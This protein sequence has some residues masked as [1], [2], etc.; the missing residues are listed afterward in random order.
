VRCGNPTHVTW[1]KAPKNI[2]GA[3]EALKKVGYSRLLAD[4]DVDANWM[5]LGDIALLRPLRGTLEELL[6]VRQGGTV[7]PY[8]AAFWKRRAAEGNANNAAHV[9]N[10]IQAIVIKGKP[11]PVDETLVNNDVYELVTLYV[12]GR[13]GADAAETKRHYDL[14]KKKGMH[15]SAANLLNYEVDGYVDWEPDLTRTKE[16]HAHE[17]STLTPANSFECPWLADDTP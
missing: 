7:T 15:A 4:W 17:L 16:F 11:L 8:A 12:E 10:E 6:A 13:D 14:L 9:L 1:L 2:I 5:P 3:H